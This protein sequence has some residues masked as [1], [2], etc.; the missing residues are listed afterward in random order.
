MGTVTGG[1]AYPFFIVG[2]PGSESQRA[3]LM[4]ITHGKYPL[5]DVSVRIQDVDQFLESARRSVATG[6]A[7]TDS[8][9]RSLQ[10][11]NQ[12]SIYQT[13]GNVIRTR[14]FHSGRLT[15]LVAQRLPS[16]S[17]SPPE[18]VASFNRLYSSA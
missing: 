3:D 15:C 9:L 4:L 6:E 12:A 13:V 11:L 7:K 16:I 2:R 5:Y 14:E 18:T 10:L 17:D 1:D 8:I